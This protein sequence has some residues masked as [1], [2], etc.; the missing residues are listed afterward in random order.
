[1]LCF[2]SSEDLATTLQTACRKDS[3]IRLMLFSTNEHFQEEGTKKDT[4]TSPAY[5]L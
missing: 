2:T 1:M 4:S 3:Q 5:A